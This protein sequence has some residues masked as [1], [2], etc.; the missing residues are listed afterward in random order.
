MKKVVSLLMISAMLVGCNG[1]NSNDPVQ[2]D[3]ICS[4]TTASEFLA[5]LAGTYDVYAEVSDYGGAYTEL[6]HENIYST[7]ITPSGQVTIQ[8][9]ISPVVF[10]IDTNIFNVTYP[11]MGNV[12]KE[13]EL[14]SSVVGGNKITIIRV[15]NN[16]DPSLDFTQIIYRNSSYD[17]NNSLNLEGQ[18]YADTSLL[19][20][21]SPYYVD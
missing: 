15:C 10:E 12:I 6:I 7:T 1:N 17:E 21:P 3:A 14:K 4:T 13:L 16:T 5:E 9:E 20:L 8:T 19:L 2:P 18:D 11:G